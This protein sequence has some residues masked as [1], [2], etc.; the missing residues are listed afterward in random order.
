M[1]PWPTSGWQVVP[2]DEIDLSLLQALSPNSRVPYRELADRMELSVTTVH[3]RIQA[4]VD[5]GII[6]KFSVYPSPRILPWVF[7]SI[8]GRSQ[9]DSLDD[10]IDRLGR[11]PSTE[12]IGP[13]SGN[14]LF[15]WGIVRDISEVSKYV[16]FAVREARIVDPYVSLHDLSHLYGAGDDKFTNMDYRILSRLLDDSRKQVEDVSAELGVSVST[17]RRRL[18]RMEKNRLILCTIQYDPSSTGDVFLIF[19]LTI[20]SGVDRT[21]VIKMIRSRY[22]KNLISTWTYDTIPG[23]IT[24]NVWAKTMTELKA[25]REDL[26]KEELFEKIVPVVPYELLYYDTWLTKYIR[27][28]A[29]PGK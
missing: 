25:L 22:Q 1:H 20:R 11:H 8:E 14:F 26:Q 3:K 5:Q 18:E 6:K 15:I 24:F 28:Q 17:V 12:R 16:D 4:L 29:S 7:V 13:A 10:V 23:L 2:L 21:E 9:A 27:E 19:F